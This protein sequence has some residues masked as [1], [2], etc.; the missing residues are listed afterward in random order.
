MRD[1][2]LSAST[3]PRRARPLAVILLVL[4]LAAALFGG[5]AAASDPSAGAPATAA[6][7]AAARPAAAASSLPCDIYAAGGTPCIAAHSTTRAL[8]AAYSGPLYQVQ[9]ASDHGYHDVGVLAA[10]GY[11][12]ASA[13]TSFCAGTS[14]IITKIY[15]QTSRHND[16]PISWGGYWKGPG[17]NGADIGAD[18]A[19]LPVTAGGHQVFG[20]KVTP[21][22][23]YRIDH[24]SGAPTGSQPEGIYM[25]TSSDYTNQWCCF[26][27]GSGENTHTDT[28]N[29]TMNS[30]Y[31]GNACWFGGCTGSGPWVEADLENG[32]YH[33]GSGSNHDPNNQGVHYPFVSAWEKNDGTSN[34]TLKYGSAASGGLTTTYSGGLPGGYSPMKTDSSLLLGTGGDNSPSGQGEFFEGAI[35]AGFP[36][37]ATE[38]AVQA[39]ITAAG[40]GG[41]GGGGTGGALRGTASGRCLDVPNQTQTNGTQTELWDCNG[42]TNQQWTVTGAKELRVY[43]S[44]CLDDEAGGTANGTRAIIWDCN[45]RNNQKWNVNSDGSITNV[46]TGL[47]L[48]ASAYGTANGTLVQLWACTGAGNQKWSRN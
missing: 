32:M 47:C 29:A 2:V 34:F 4:A 3:G 36:S 38:N 19:A 14:C 27:Y 10:G 23:G 30:L 43:G 45:G 42:G 35:T 44:K 6:H 17:A 40:Y 31:W 33:T 22:T 46:Q 37:D 21:G 15:D 16:L 8:F 9:R 39:G 20:V 48:D 26:D 28:G 12:D 24:A 25:V 41:S 11:A 5:R 7:P 1:P 13:Q 18:A